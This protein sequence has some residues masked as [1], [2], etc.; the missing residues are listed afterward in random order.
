M[1]LDEALEALRDGDRRAGVDGR[2]PGRRKVG[3]GRH[4]VAL[5][6]RALADAMLGGVALERAAPLRA[7]LAEDAPLGDELA[8][9]VEVQV[10][11]VGSDGPRREHVAELVRQ[12]PLALD[13]ADEAD[14]AAIDAPLERVRQLV[15]DER[16]AAALGRR[17]GVAIGARARREL[18]L[19]QRQALHADALEDRG[20]AAAAGIGELERA[21]L[22]RA[23]R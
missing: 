8:L 19:E 2:A 11:R 5:R 22:D 10:L 4:D 3:P 13:A 21:P 16:R 7:V 15:R 17:E 9:A 14:H 18:A 20:L 1:A 23:E 12:E 6:Q